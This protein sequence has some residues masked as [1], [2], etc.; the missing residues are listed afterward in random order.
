VL[1]ASF[2]TANDF[3]N[4][5]SLVQ[6]PAITPLQGGAPSAPTGLRVAGLLFDTLFRGWPG[7]AI[8]RAGLDTDFSR[9]NDSRRLLVALTNVNVPER[10]PVNRHMHSR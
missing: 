3:S 9:E 5:A 8:R 1:P 7:Q 4:L 10:S 2:V 6:P